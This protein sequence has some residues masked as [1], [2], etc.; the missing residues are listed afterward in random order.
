MATSTV[1]D[2]GW[3]YDIDSWPGKFAGETVEMGTIFV[4]DDYFPTV[5]MSLKE[6]RT[7]RNANDTASVV[8]NEAAIK[9]LRIKDPVNKMIKW[10]DSQFKIVGVVNDALMVSPF[11]SADP[12]MFYTSPST[13]SQLMYRLS[14]HIS[15]AKALAQLNLIFNKYNPAY[16]YKYTF[17]DQDYAAKFKLEQLIGKLAG[18]FAALAIFISCLGLFGLSA[19]IAEQ[20]VKE[21]GI[22]KVL[23]AS[24]SQLWLLLS[25]EFVLLVLISCVLASPIA[26]YFLHGWLLQYDYRISIG[27][28]V[29]VL[30]GLVSTI[31]TLVT[32]SYKA[33]PAAVANP[34]KSLRTE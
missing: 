16:P 30:A 20:R 12:T 15:T 2:V 9:R 29:F 17:E 19:Y 21:I 7:F 24:V 27:V 1:T 25:R 33:I 11:S 10:G 28:G 34:V 23:G 18:L 14:R 22:R 26:W 4:A 5:G 31:I 32:V 3:H 6:G 13:K 8:F